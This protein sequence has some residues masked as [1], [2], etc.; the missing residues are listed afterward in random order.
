MKR[1]FLFLAPILFALFLLMRHP[2]VTNSVLSS[3]Y[4]AGMTGRVKKYMVHVMIAE[5]EVPGDFFWI[6]RILVHT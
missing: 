3:E 2:D 5:I 6:F 1:I 4:K